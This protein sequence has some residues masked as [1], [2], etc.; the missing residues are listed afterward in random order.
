MPCN[1]RFRGAEAASA[2]DKRLSK[3]VARRGRLHVANRRPVR[4]RLRARPRPD[5]AGYIRSRHVR[6][7]PRPATM[8][9]C[10]RSPRS[11]TCSAGAARQGFWPRWPGTGAT[12]SVRTKA[13]PTAGPA[14]CGAPSNSCGSPSRHGC[15]KTTASKWTPRAAGQAPLPGP[16]QRRLDRAR[17]RPGRPVWPRRRPRRVVLRLPARRENG[18]GQPDRPLLGHRARRGERAPGRRRPARSRA[19]PARPARGQGIQRQGLRRQPGHPRHRRPGSP[20]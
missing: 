4:L 19:R 18:P 9:S 8:L 1:P 11:G 5:A 3:S 14:G 12:C 16:R 20:R 10:W 7:L 6:G 15:R 13:R 2:E 17:Q